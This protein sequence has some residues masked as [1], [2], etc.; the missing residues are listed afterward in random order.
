MDDRDWTA[1][2][3]TELMALNKRKFFTYSLMLVKILKHYHIYFLKQK[4]I[5]S[6]KV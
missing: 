2:N 3:W 6:E 5:S 4:I 1:V